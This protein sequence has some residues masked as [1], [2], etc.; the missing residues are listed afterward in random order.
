MTTIKGYTDDELDF[1]RLNYQ[2]MTIRQLS[3]KF[4]KSVGSISAALHKMNLSKQKH[5]KWT[6]EEKQFLIDHYIDMTSKE[7]SKYINHS[8]A[9]INTQRD[10]LGLVRNESWTDDEI[11]FLIDN[12]AN[13]SHEEI[14]KQIN[15]TSIAVCAKCFEL[16]LYKKELP[17]TADET[18][19][20]KQNY[21]TMSTKDIAT[22][23]NRSINAIKVH[24][25]R[26][27]FKKYPYSCD[28]DFFNVIDTEEKAY[29]LGFLTADGWISKN[30]V[31][32]SGC[33]GI[34]LKY[35]DLCHL[36]KFNKSIHGNYK[37]V[38]RWK[39]CHISKN[40]NKW[41]HMCCIRIYSI[42]MYNSL[43]KLG[44]TN[45]KTYDCY[46]PDIPQ[47]LIKHYIR[48][49]FDGDGRFGL[50]N[51][52]LWVS[53]CTASKSFNDCIVHELQKEDIQVQQYDYINE[54]GTQMYVPELTN[55]K[56]RIKFLNWIYDDANIYLDR[57]YKKY[58]KAI[59]QYRS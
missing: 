55:N 58:L 21:M 34:E 23:L 59:K 49:Y 20:V 35:S 48:G 32:N 40:P 19:Y 22:H 42:D 29:W 54:F 41:N 45:N 37:I 46:I 33:V 3:T 8:I 1:I 10:K 4:N 27:G 53:F 44:F 57:K 30:E 2:S 31:K 12:Y 13:M 51:N 50:S 9:A 28:Y 7:M 18:D 25:Q 38:D 17:W 26:M 47:T 56:A 16:N 36:K 15:R 6:E 11:M 5:N 14:G 43:T 52:R 24:A 39:Q